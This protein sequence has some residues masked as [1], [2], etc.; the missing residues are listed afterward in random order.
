[1][2]ETNQPTLEPAIVVIFGITGDLSKRK[3]LPALYH[4]FKDSL[5]DEHTII[6][7]VT[8]REISVSQLLGEVE[9]CIN[10]TDGI[11]DPS[12]VANMKSRMQMLQLDITKDDEYDRLLIEL[13]KIEDKQGLCMNRLYYLSIPPQVTGTIVTLLGKHGL[14]KSCNTA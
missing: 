7:G 4:L 12:V 13:N 8:R 5:L 6:L 11:C 3:L 2:T 9:L 1:M 10:E 14:N